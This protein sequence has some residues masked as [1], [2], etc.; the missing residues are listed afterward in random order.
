MSDDKKKQARRVSRPLPLLLGQLLR[1]NLVGVLNTAVDFG[2]FFI[3]ERLGMPYL[4]AQTC[5][6]GCGIANSY[7]C[8]KYWTFGLSGSRGRELLRFVVVNLG[9]LATSVILIYLFHSLLHLSLAAAKVAATIITMLANFT[10]SRMW[11]FRQET[12]PDST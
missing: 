3:L 9:V 8:N 5:S 4:L 2:L 1:F 11:V 6:Y 12:G 10:A 7:L